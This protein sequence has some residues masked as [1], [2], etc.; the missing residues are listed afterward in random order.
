LTVVMFGIFQRFNGAGETEEELQYNEFLTA[1]E[2]GEVAELT[3][4][5][6][7]NVYLITGRLA[8]QD[9]QESFTSVVPYNSVSDLEQITDTARSQENLSLTVAPEE[10]PSPWASMLV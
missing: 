10:E 4:Q 1:L 9:E 3:I 2:A 6:E 7:N 8:D 5:P